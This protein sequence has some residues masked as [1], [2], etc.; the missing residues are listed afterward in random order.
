MCVEAHFDTDVETLELRPRFGRYGKLAP[1]V[2]VPLSRQVRAECTRCGTHLLA[3]P[4]DDGGLSGTCP[5]CLSHTVTA[6]AVH[7]ATA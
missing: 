2:G 4:H 6:V 5:V 3:I 1:Q 7:H